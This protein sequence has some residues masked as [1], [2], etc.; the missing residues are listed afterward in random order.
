MLFAIEIFPDLGFYFYRTFRI[1]S[2][3]KVVLHTATSMISSNVSQES[4]C[5]KMQEIDDEVRD[6]TM[7]PK[8]QLKLDNL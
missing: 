8:W 4:C 1:N 6:I 5:Y 3:H 7:K 2:L